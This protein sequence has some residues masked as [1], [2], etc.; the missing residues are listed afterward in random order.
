LRDLKR[1]KNAEEMVIRQMA[2]PLEKRRV[3]TVIETK[4]VC[5]W[6]FEPSYS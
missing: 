2:M 1:L 5:S 4:D 3:E 6:C